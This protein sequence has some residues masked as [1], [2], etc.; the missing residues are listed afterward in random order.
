MLAV[1]YAG[2]GRPSGEEIRQ[3][4]AYGAT[5]ERCGSWSPELPKEH[6]DGANGQAWAYYQALTA[7]DAKTATA[8]E[9]RLPSTARA[10]VLDVIAE[11]FAEGDYDRPTFARRMRTALR[12]ARDSVRG[13]QDARVNGEGAGRALSDGQAVKDWS[14]GAGNDPETMLIEMALEAAQTHWEDHPPRIEA[15]P[16]LR[17]LRA[18][19]E[20]LL[21]SEQ[22][23]RWWAVARQV[24]S[25]RWR[26]VAVDLDAGAADMAKPVAKE[27]RPPAW[28]AFVHNSE[29]F[30]RAETARALV[31]R[32]FSLCGVAF[33]GGSTAEQ[34]QLS[35][36]A[37]AAFDDP[38]VDLVPQ[39]RPAALA[40]HRRRS[41][42]RRAA[43]NVP[44]SSAPTS[45][46]RR[47][48][49]C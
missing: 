20:E 17:K 13:A 26:G 12:A 16:E 35:R 46:A 39:W 25:V 23:P 48:E 19:L 36:A 34:K 2:D 33:P 11:A 44:N 3:P 47:G 4:A 30:E 14:R 29:A 41:F 5:L 32:L 7:G 9:R 27:G 8:A 10:V 6:R 42:E 38:Q 37:T 31:G 43:R 22:A 49:E 1:P 40:D 18:A 21:A 45:V 15:T 24:L 28:G